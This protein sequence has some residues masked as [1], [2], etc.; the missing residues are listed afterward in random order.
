MATCTSCNLKI[1]D[2]RKET[3][4]HV[5]SA[6]LHRSCAIKEDSK[7][8]CDVCYTI[9]HENKNSTADLTIPNTIRRTYIELYRSCPYKFYM[10]VIKGIKAPPNI[11]TQVG[12]DVHILLEKLSLDPSIP[13]KQ[14]IKEFNN[15]WNNY[16]ENL[17]TDNKIKEDMYI[18]AVNS[19]TNAYKIIPDLPNLLSTEDKVI[20]DIGDNL[21]KISATIDRIDALEDGIEVM[22][23]KTGKVMVGQKLSSDLQAPLYIYAA[24][25]KYQKP[26]KQFTFYYLQNKKTRTFVQSAGDNYICNVRKRKYIINPTDAI[27]KV[28]SI[29][30]QILKGN[31]NI[32]YDTRK[33]FFTC[34]T[35]HIKEMGKCQGAELESWKQN[36]KR[37][38]T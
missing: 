13:Q 21:P 29:F 1:E 18:R 36:K 14:L 6:P 9:K 38:M 32:P 22:D 10:E 37:A 15:L 17:F 8:F 33:M 27:R 30:S 2:L 25:Q 26:V 24:R 16:N 11:Y 3:R 35:C 12:I 5:C 7:Y 31:F 19:I 23:W 20:I 4:C 28:K 34:K